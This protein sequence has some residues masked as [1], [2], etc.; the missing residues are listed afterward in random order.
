MGTPTKILLTGFEPFGQLSENPSQIV[1]EALSQ[2]EWAGAEVRHLILP[3]EFVAAMEK[4][5]DF[6]RGDWFP[7]IV[8][9]LGVAKSRMTVT[10]ERFAV[11][12]MDTANGDNAGYFPDEVPVVADAPLAYQ[13]TI[14]CKRIIQYLR[15]NGYEAKLSNSAGT[16]VC[17][18]VLFNSLHILSADSSNN[19]FRPATNARCGFIHL[20][21]FENMDKNLQLETLKTI[22]LWLVRNHQQAFPEC[23]SPGN[24]Q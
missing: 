9:H 3:V 4:M 20:P 12:I 10:L 6:Y 2:Q 22:I 5:A 23:P 1:A 16:Y 19:S 14:P 7:D 24:V 13:T 17:N 8:L 15:D 18:A 11:N 21:L